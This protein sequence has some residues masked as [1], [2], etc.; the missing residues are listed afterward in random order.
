MGWQL[1]DALRFSASYA[2]LNATEPNDRKPGARATPS[3][4]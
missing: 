4:A 1:S 2:Y 3:E